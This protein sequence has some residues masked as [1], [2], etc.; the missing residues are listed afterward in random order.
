VITASTSGRFTDYITASF[1]PDVAGTY[2][3]QL[4]S[5][6]GVN[7]QKMTWTITASAPAAITA[8]ASKIFMSTSTSTDAGADFGAAYGTYFGAC[9]PQPACQTALNA[10]STL[11]AANASVSFATTPASA[12]SIVANGIVRLRNSFVADPTNAANIKATDIHAALPLTVAISGHG[13]VA[14]GSRAIYGTTVTDSMAASNTTG[15]DSLDHTFYVKSDGT[16][17]TATIT[18]S[19]GSL[20]LGT[21][22]VVFYGSTANAKATA[23]KTIASTSGSALAGAVQVVVTD[24]LGN[25]V[26]GQEGNIVATSSDTSVLA[27]Q[28]AGNSGCVYDTVVDTVGNYLCNVSAVAN[29]ASGKTATI[30]FTVVKSGTTTVL[31]SAPALTFTTGGSTISSLTLVPAASSYAPGDKVTMTLTAKDSSGNPVADGQYG[32]FL[33]S[34]SNASTYSGL[35][36]SANT[37]NVP[38][39]KSAAVSPATTNGYTFTGGLTTS[40]FYAPYTSGTVVMSGT[41]ASTGSNLAGALQGTTL[42]SSVSVTNT[43]D[44]A[45]QAAVDAANEATDAANAATDAANNAMDSADAA[46]QAALDAGDKADAALAAVTDL[47][48]KVSAIAT[49]IAALS[50][51]V[52]KI[53][54]KVKA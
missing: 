15:Y 21:R 9:T 32:V 16:T 29:V 2:V 38:F 6:N 42:S 37:T 30:T 46:Q 47:A 4:A 44:A 13:Y 34:T 22:T 45:A 20:V 40:S 19:A 24:A 3:I 28:T 27:S 18:F 36:L 7:N 35:T 54:A 53:A 51:L 11:D 43:T 1:T 52:K 31:A 39:A 10:E 17:G 5:T 49:Q 33:N 25:G 12:G 50:A 41:L 26:P 8:G 48:T 14:L 23:V